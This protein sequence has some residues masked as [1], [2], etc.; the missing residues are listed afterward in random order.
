MLPARGRHRGFFEEAGMVTRARKVAGQIIHPIAMSK[1]PPWQ[2][3]D[4]AAEAL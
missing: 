2:D 4:A 1:R 3:G